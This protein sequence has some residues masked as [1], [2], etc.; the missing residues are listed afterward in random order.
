MTLSQGFLPEAGPVSEDHRKARIVI[1]AAGFKRPNGGG[2][3]RELA[4]ELDCSL[5]TAHAIANNPAHRINQKSDLAA[6]L[7]RAYEG[8]AL[9]PWPGE[10]QSIELRNRTVLGEG[11]KVDAEAIAE[12]L[13]PL[14]VSRWSEIAL[15]ETISPAERMFFG[16]QAS[17]TLFDC[18][19]P[20]KLAYKALQK[21]PNSKI[22]CPL[23]IKERGLAV[24]DVLKNLVIQED[25]LVRLYGSDDQKN[26]LG[27]FL[28]RTRIRSNWL[29]WQ[30][31]HSAPGLAAML[32]KAVSEGLIEDLERMA[33]IVPMDNAWLNNA[34][35]ALI[36]TSDWKRSARLGGKLFESFPQ[37]TTK[38]VLGIRPIFEDRSVW[39]GV[40]AILAD[41]MTHE[42]AIL[43]ELLVEGA[44]STLSQLL[45]TLI[46]LIHAGEAYESLSSLC[47]E[48]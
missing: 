41:P 16:L 44:S 5:G 42:A 21:N 2:I 31:A 8:V 25:A 4:A 12:L 26:H 48:E 7:T 29:A 14:A 13:L 47:L 1:H 11:A 33:D 34:W 27:M 35:N 17:R 32:Q 18:A 36:R 45:P 22:I 23:E 37:M 6:R 3:Y 9:M 43:R 24:I 39:P 20:S 46:E 10:R 15:D 19:T 30:G 28:L 38:R 40:A